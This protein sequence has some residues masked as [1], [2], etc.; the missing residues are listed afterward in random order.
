LI[1]INVSKRYGNLKDGP[2]DVRNHRWFIDTSFNDLLNRLIKAPYIPIVDKSKI[3]VENG[4]VF[5]KND[6]E[7]VEKNLDPFS[8]W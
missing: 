8:K 1:V 5:N 4:F 7:K 6:A 3:N 2:D